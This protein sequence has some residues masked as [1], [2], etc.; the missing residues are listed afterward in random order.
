MLKIWKSSTGLIAGWVSDA[1][2]NQACRDEIEQAWNSE[3]PEEA[4]Y[5]FPIKIPSLPPMQSLSAGKIEA[6]VS[7]GYEVLND[8]QMQE[9]VDN[10]SD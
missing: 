1:A 10:Y 4:G 9:I 5:C 8:T 6:L 2:E 7:R 3:F